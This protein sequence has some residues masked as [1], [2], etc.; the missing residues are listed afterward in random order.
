MKRQRVKIYA[1]STKGSPYVP[2]V[3][4]GIQTDKGGVAIVVNERDDSFFLY[5]VDRKEGM[6]HSVRLTPEVITALL[7]GTG[8]KPQPVTVPIQELNLPAFPWE[9]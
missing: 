2:A 5:E 6:V 1:S 9:Q 4:Y 8:E 3:R 7:T